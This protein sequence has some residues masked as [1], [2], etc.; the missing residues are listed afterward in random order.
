MTELECSNRFKKA[1]PGNNLGMVFQCPNCQ[2]Q[3]IRGTDLVKGDAECEVFEAVC[4]RA[5][6]D[7]FWSRASQTVANH[8]REVIFLVK[9]AEMLD[10]PSIFPQM[11][12]FSRGHHL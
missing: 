1:H 5:T 7:A 2:C 11:G 10:I 9:Y 3:N 12:T 8:A 6:M 4:T